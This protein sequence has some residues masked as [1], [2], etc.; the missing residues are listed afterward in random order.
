MANAWKYKVTVMTFDRGGIWDV[1]RPP[2]NDPCPIPDP[3]CRLNLF[4]GT[5]FTAGPLYSVPSAVGLLLANGAYYLTSGSGVVRSLPT[6]LA[7]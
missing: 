2:S 5:E 1:I 6:Y 4:L 3:E 7:D